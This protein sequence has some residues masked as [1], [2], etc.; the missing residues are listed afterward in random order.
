QRRK[1]RHPDSPR[2]LRFRRERRRLRVP[3]TSGDFGVM[4]YWSI[5]VLAPITPI[6]HHSSTPPLHPRFTCS[7]VHLFSSRGFCYNGSRCR[8][9][10][11]PQPPRLRRPHYPRITKSHRFIV[12]RLSQEALIMRR[13]G[14][15]LIEL[16]VVIAIIAILAAI[17]FPVFAQAREKAR[18]TSCLSN[19][20]Q[21]GLAEAMYM[22]D[23]D[24][25][26][27]ELIPGG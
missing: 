24:G 21:L 18:S 9:V 11:A 23:Y 12:S 15:T 8:P 27:H 16:L 7:P 22:Q 4:E 13:H 1:A 3:P 17:L 26:I 10:P 20:K 6:L 2:R 25:L 19:M 5:G 14:F